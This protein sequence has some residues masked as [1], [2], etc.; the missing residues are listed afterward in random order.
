MAPLGAIGG[1]SGALAGHAA[2]L[3]ITLGIFVGTLS[4]NRAPSPAR[5]AGPAQAD[6]ASQ[7]AH[8]ETHQAPRPLV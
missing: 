4:L 2:V 6:P 8:V 7:V 5:A 3:A 1:A